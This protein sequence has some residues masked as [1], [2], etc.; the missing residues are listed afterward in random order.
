MLQAR[1]LT[2]VAAG[3][4]AFHAQRTAAMAAG[5]GEII[6]IDLGTTNS[7][8]AVMEGKNPRVIENSEGARTTPS[9]VAILDD[10]E[11]LVGQP[12][13]RQAV[14]NPENTFYAVKRL[15]GR[16]FDDE[17][18]T[19]ISN[20]VPYKIIKSPSNDDAWVEA[21]GEKYSPSQIGS[22]VLGKMKETSENFLGSK[23]S[24]A[25]IT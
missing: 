19:Q 16:K 4:R 17:E 22:M 6:G 25:V 2:K 20:L 14:T 8:V 24:K 7:C 18:V 13:K 10:D 11:R 12:A 5:A 9:V 3:V 21:H 15:I 23:V 1:N